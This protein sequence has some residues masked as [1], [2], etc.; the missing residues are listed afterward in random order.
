MKPISYFDR[1]TRAFARTL[2][3][4]LFFVQ[5]YR[6]QAICTS[7]LKTAKALRKQGVSLDV[8]LSILVYKY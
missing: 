8:A 5:K 4:G 7:T 1:S 2:S 6:N 3:I